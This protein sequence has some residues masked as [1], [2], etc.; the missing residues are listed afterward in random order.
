[1]K[2]TRGIILDLDGVLRRGKK[3]IRGSVEAVA[4]L[5]DCGVDICYLTNNSTRARTVILS[6]LTGMG[7]P[8]RDVV[9]SAQAAGIYIHREF[10]ATRCLVVGE[11][12]LNEELS[13]AGHETFTAGEHN[14]EDSMDIVVAGLDR[15]L[16]YS[17]IKDALRA[18]RDG[19][20]LIATNRD[21]TLPSEDGTVVPG[22][23]A[24][25]SAIEGCTGLEAVV[26]GKPMPFST[27]I[28]LEHLDLRPDEVLMVGDR[29]D[30][31]ILAGRRAGCEV[32]MVLTGDVER[33]EKA[34]F[35][36]FDDLEDLVR[37]ML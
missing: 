27:R 29:P 14:E 19:A 4:H 7:F 18:V 3:P 31:D 5:V 37:K 2:N 23:G 8:E 6:E 32:A 17:R 34:D 35:P 28:A 25:V 33:P 22:A 21:P 30:T 36:V 11:H 10:G 12:G 13:L 9:S 1:M 20:S 15:G 16:T 24:T 26:V